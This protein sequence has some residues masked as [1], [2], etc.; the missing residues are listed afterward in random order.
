MGL[1]PVKGVWMELEERNKKALFWSESS[2]SLEGSWKTTNVGHI[3]F[4]IESL[5][6]Q[7]GLFDMVG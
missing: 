6:V 2:L 1:I 4:Q 3:S 5:S 7:P